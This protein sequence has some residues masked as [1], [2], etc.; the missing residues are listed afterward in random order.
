MLNTIT[1][2]K[3]RHKK[4]KKQI[5]DVKNR[6]KNSGVS[7]LSDNIKL[8][9]QLSG[10]TQRQFGDKI[11]A[12]KDKMYSYE[13]DNAKPLEIYVERIAQ[14][15]GISA[16]ELQTHRFHSRDLNA[17]QIKLNIQSF[18][19]YAETSDVKTENAPPSD[20]KDELIALL[21]ENKEIIKSLN[22]LE[23]NLLAL[24]KIVFELKALQEPNQKILYESAS[25]TLDRSIESLHEE[26]SNIASSLI[27]RYEKM[28][29]F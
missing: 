8:I 22:R 15:A 6:K 19:F 5:L 24:R 18:D 12:N 4:Q 28:G 16:T 10:C 26:A 7:I 27:Q 1:E 9:R 23:S 13:A 21:K 25:K 29:I 3:I 20:M 11:G 17:K 14:I 2:S